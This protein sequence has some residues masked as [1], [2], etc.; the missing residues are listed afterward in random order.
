LLT[1]LRNANIKS[2]T[3]NKITVTRFRNNYYILVNDALIRE[4]SNIN[5]FGSLI[6]FNTGKDSEISADFIRVS[7]LTDKPAPSLTEK[8]GSTD[9]IHIEWISPSSQ[10]TSIESFSTRVRT[11]IIAESGLNDVLFYVNGVAS[12]GEADIKP[13]S[14]ETGGFQVEKVLNF[15]P[16]ENSVYL[17]ASNNYGSTKSDLR[18]FT[19]PSATTPGI[20]WVSPVSTTALVNKDRLQIEV[21]VQSPTTLQ[22]L[23]V[24]VNGMPQ[25]ES[26]TFQAPASGDCNYRWQV[27]VVL[28][29]GDNEISVIAR[30]LAGSTTSDSRLVKRTSSFT[31]KR[32]ALIF[33]NSQYGTR[34]SLKNPVNDANL[35][36]G[37]LKD[38]NFE[39]IKKTNA[40]K[41]EMEQA[42]IEFS[43]KLPEYNVAL[44]Y[45]AGHG[46]QVDGVNY[47][48]PVDATLEQ[49]SDCQWQ[50]VSVTD[51][52]KQ[53]EK[54]PDNINIVIL[55]ACRNN[56]F[57]NWVRGNE[58]GFKFLPNVSG[59]II[60]YATVEGATAADGSGLNGIYTE[61]LVKQMVLPQPIES[62][63]KRTRVQVEMRSNGMQSPQETTGLRGDFYFVK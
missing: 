37:T 19:I 25:S 40:T 4:L 32:L 56:P 29:E 60:G 23:E 21:C 41:Q 49:K 11:K 55:D 34:V 16:G 14:G 54:Y 46:I 10:K 62:V 52:V 8:V 33:G 15:G 39:V 26:R 63:F 53:F 35:I 27:P 36:E 50:A 48:I 20:S 5:T 31:E 12:K 58:A 42:I 24:L 59:T 43:R 38:L 13:L 61:E 44:F 1:S 9:A 2:G 30:N 17:I 47:L 57:T 18:Y 45:Y 3:V 22:S 51:V 7:Y 28:R 6:G